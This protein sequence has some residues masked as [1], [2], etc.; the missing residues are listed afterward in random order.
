MYVLISHSL[1]MYTYRC[2]VE[3]E[4]ALYAS[5]EEKGADGNGGRRSGSGGVGEE[6]SLGKF[7]Y[8]LHG[9]PDAK[10]GT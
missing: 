4:D 10:N 5:G 7:S 3:S 9:Q 2:D 1:N 8:H 6:R